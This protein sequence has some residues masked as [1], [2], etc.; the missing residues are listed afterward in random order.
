MK[1]CLSTGLP[2]LVLRR[3]LEI[4]TY[5]ATNH[6]AIANIL[7]HFDFSLIPDYS[8]SKHSEVKKDKG[9][10]KIKEGGDLSNFSVNIQRGDVPLILLLK[11]LG[12]PLF[13]RSSAHLEQVGAALT[14]L[15]TCPLVFTQLYLIIIVVGSFIW[16]R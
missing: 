7:F 16:C 8:F 6:S 15:I 11:L 3:V 13:I 9:K 2:P 1:V 4:L 5:L 14:A 12:Q 10:E